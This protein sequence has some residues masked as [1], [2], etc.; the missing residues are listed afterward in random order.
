VH[1]PEHSGGHYW[2]HIGCTDDETGDP[3]GLDPEKKGI[4]IISGLGRPFE[5]LGCFKFEERSWYHM[6][7]NLGRWRLKLV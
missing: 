1:R 3:M 4:D 6:I 5:S 2:M 7:F